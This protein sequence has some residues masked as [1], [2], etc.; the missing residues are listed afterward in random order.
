MQRIRSP[1]ALAVLTASAFVLPLRAA[2]LEPPD[3]AHSGPTLAVEDTLRLVSEP[4]PEVLATAPR[5]TLDEILRHVAEGEA[6]R[7]SLIQDQAF[8]F[9]IRVAG[10]DPK[11]GPGGKSELYYESASRIYQKRPD[12]KRTVLLREWS[13]DKAHSE[14]ERGR[15]FS[16]SGQS[17]NTDRGRLD[18]KGEGKPHGDGK[19]KG[20]H[21]SVSFDADM[22]ERFIAFA[23]NPGMRDRFRFRIEDR[24]IMGDQVVYVLAFTPRS[25]VDPLPSGRVWINTND[26]VILREEFWYRDRSPLP[27]F[28]DSIESC[29]IERSRI[30]QRYWVFER[31]LARVTLTNPFLW[32]AK[33]SG[34]KLSKQ[35]D[36]VM[37]R[38]DWIINGDIPDSLFAPAEGKGGK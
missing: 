27:W 6:H 13:R 34:E 2:S 36:F 20:V 11:S 19:D 14:Q 35:M 29:V 16:D 24:K 18:A 5:Q 3:P 10:Q 23:F 31:I 28:I 33:L 32:M 8:T 25:S 38:T 37:A 17:G 15:D 26:F 12:K 9:L 21:V 7:D 22:S 1:F 30:D 4:Y